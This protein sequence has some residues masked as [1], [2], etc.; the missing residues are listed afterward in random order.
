VIFAETFSAAQAVPIG[1]AVIAIRAPAAE[2]C[3]VGCFPRFP[4][5]FFRRFFD[6]SL[7]GFSRRSFFN[8]LWHIFFTYVFDL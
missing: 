2:F 7:R 6:R 8:F 3:F 5:G 1:V 4:R